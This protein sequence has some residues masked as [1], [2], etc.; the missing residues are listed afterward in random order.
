MDHNLLLVN[1]YYILTNM[2]SVLIFIFYKFVGI[3]YFFL[4]NKGMRREERK[5]RKISAKSGMVGRSASTL[6]MGGAPPCV[7]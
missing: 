3:F 1:M 6:G 2:L 4:K 5:N 7:F